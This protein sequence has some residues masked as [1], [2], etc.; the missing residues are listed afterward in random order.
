MIFRIEDYVSDDD[1]AW[2]ETNGYALTLRPNPELLYA[3]FAI[4][5]KPGGPITGS[6]TLSPNGCGGARALADCARAALA[7]A[8]NSF[9]KIIEEGKGGDGK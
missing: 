3:Y 5:E 9:R 1:K 4:L 2:L 6:V 7:T 8:F